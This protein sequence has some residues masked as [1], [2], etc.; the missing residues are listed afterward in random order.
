[1]TT[2][3]TP[4]TPASESLV[5]GLVIFAAVMLLVS[6]ILE[7]L[8]GIMALAHDDVFVSTSDYTFQF[9][10]TSWGWI[11]L[12][13][14]ILAVVVGI[15]LFRVST[16]ARVLG[17]LMAS[18]LIIANFLWLPYYPLWSVI[19]IAFYGFVIWAL[20]VVRPGGARAGGTAGGAGT[21][22]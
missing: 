22:P 2:T 18:L 13:L 11:H 5:S 20:C 9:S 6:G 3:Y 16:W 15:G 12:I 10:L 7:I 17:V 19:A 14:G 21:A 4:R 1:M 8:R